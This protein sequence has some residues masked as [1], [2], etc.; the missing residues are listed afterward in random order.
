MYLNVKKLS[1]II[2]KRLVFTEISFSVKDNEIV[3]VYGKNGSGKTVLLKCLLGLT[4]VDGGFFSFQLTGDQLGVCFQFPEHLIYHRTV[5]EEVVSLVRDEAKALEVMKKA[6]IR[7]RR[8]NSPLTL[9][10]GQKRLMF[11]FA[12]MQKNKLLIFD[13]PL[14]SLDK[15]S[16]KMIIDEML[17]FKR[18]KGAIIYT[19]NRMED[20]YFA[21]KLVC[22]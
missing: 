13:E 4:D 12:L 20:I 14:T 15:K 2:N 7:D 1:K 21:D 18:G 17:R 10:E 3:C 8:D 6:N 11:L 9:S 19:A 16:K 22:L 5:Y